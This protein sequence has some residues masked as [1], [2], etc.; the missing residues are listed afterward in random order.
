MDEI[1][2]ALTQLQTALQ[3]NGI[4]PIAELRF[5]QQSDLDTFVY[6][7]KEHFHMY[8]VAGVDNEARGISLLGVSLTL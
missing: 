4:G 6:L 1:V 2:L 5:D 3:E 8:P 7:A